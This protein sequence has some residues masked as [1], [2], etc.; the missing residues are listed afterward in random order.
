MG[1]TEGVWC[2]AVPY[3]R[4]DLLMDRWARVVDMIWY[5][6]QWLDPRQR[7]LGTLDWVRQYGRSLHGRIDF[8]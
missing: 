5:E 4:S 1:L 8:M 7:M 6:R 2:V 3:L